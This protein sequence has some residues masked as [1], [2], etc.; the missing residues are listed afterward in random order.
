MAEQTA[1]SAHAARQTQFVAQVNFNK[2]GEVGWRLYDICYRG[3]S[4]PRETW[5]QEP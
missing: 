1:E 4:W 3:H 2:H 5:T